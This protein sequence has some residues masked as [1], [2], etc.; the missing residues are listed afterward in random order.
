VIAM[1]GEHWQ[2]HGLE[3]VFKIDLAAIALKNVLMFRVH[4]FKVSVILLLLLSCAIVDISIL[5][6]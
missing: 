1:N 2:R 5:V 6:V 4:Y 3:W